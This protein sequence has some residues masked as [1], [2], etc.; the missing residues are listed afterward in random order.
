ML[1]GAFLAVAVYCG[2][3]PFKSGAM[4]GFPGF[5][6]Y[7]VDQPPWAELPTAQDA[8]NLLQKAELRFLGQVQG[9]E[10]VVFD[11]KG[12]GPYVGV[13]DGRVLFWDGSSWTD[14]AY[15]SPNR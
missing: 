2:L 4:V 1:A 7:G 14:F 5:E 3:D 8:E 9:P 6:T 12:R 11:Q 15:T 13:A 10:S